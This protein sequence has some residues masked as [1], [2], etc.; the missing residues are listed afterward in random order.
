MKTGLVLVMTSRES[1]RIT[2]CYFL[3]EI[4]SKQHYTQ[5]YEQLRSKQFATSKE[6]GISIL[7]ITYGNIMKSSPLKQYVSQNLV[8]GGGIKKMIRKDTGLS[9]NIEPTQDPLLN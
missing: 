3:D 2:G 5:L 9:N 1:V 8:G 6:L 7:H 4:L